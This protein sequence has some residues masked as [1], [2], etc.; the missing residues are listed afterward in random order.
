VNAKI[1]FM[2][3]CLAALGVVVAGCSSDSTSTLTSNE[4]P[5]IPPQNVSVT[6]SAF[7]D[8]VIRWDANTQPTLK[9]YNV[10][11]NDVAHSQIALLTAEPTIVTSYLDK[12]AGH[13]GQVEY[14]VTSVSTRGSESSPAMA[15][16]QI[17][18]PTPKGDKR[19]GQD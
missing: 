2:V 15:V 8:V 19:S 3:V 6:M 1:F 5:I 16:I 9:G 17:E 14:R 4:A 12:G 10:Y 7:G 18:D 11:R 13:L